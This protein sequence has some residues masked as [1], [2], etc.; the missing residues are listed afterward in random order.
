MKLSLYLVLFCLLCAGL[1]AGELINSFDSVITLQTDGSV[2]VRERIDLSSNAETVKHGITRELPN[3]VRGDWGRRVPLPLKVTRVMVDGR[4][5]PIYTRQ[6]DSS[7]SVVL[8]DELIDMP[9]GKHRFELDYTLKQAVHA[10]RGHDEL[11]WSVVGDRVILP[12]IQATVTV[13]LP[14]VLHRQHVAQD[15][16]TGSYG[17]LDRRTQTLWLD[18]QTVRI[19]STHTLNPREMFTMALRWP[20]GLVSARQPGAGTAWMVM[21]LCV[22]VIMTVLLVAYVLH[23]YLRSRGVPSEGLSPQAP[24][25]MSPASVR[26]LMLDKCDAIGLA[27]S[28][29]DMAEK[30]YVNIELH[31]SGF[32]IKRTGGDDAM[33]ATEQRLILTTLLQKDVS[34]RV[35]RSYQPELQ[36]LLGEFTGCVRHRW[37]FAITR[38]RLLCA[39]VFVL[40][41]LSVTGILSL[42]G[43]LNPVPLALCSLVWAVWALGIGIHALTRMQRSSQ[44]RIGLAVGGI[45]AL[46][47]LLPVAVLWRMMAAETY[48][49]AV[50]VLILWG[51]TL[52]LACD[53]I[54]SLAGRAWFSKLA[55]FRLSLERTICRGK[56]MGVPSAKSVPAQL[57]YALALGMRPSTAASIP[58][59]IL[60]KKNPRLTLYHLCR[61]MDLDLTHSAVQPGIPSRS[62][63]LELCSEAP[64]PP[65]CA[66]HN[67]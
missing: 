10:G 5:M 7:L 11:L 14:E 36:R 44:N 15:A 51:G 50:C 49:A 31:R 61:R 9:P 2:L 47:M 12:I 52:Q 63:L 65:D 18:A 16:F 29:I 41:L 58:W 27:C 42:F 4:K 20:H 62:R 56:H 66:E 59:L 24:V 19:R 57:G 22:L 32:T 13:H 35:K 17:K 67:T 21:I 60:P 25:G 64:I 55:A 46:I 3:I 1:K 6:M 28:L 54:P 45:Y 40:G 33:L 39:S 26:Y 43:P 48:L 8:G 38:R 34:F 23:S 37:R 53:S 30:G